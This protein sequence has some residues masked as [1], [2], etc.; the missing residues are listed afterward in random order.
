MNDLIYLLEGKRTDLPTE[1]ANLSITNKKGELIFKV[2][3]NASDSVS[4]EVFDFEEYSDYLGYG[5][6]IAKIIRAAKCADIEA[7]KAALTNQVPF[8]VVETK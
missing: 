2:R 7:V 3:V 8:E 5:V 4:L 1:I 6:K